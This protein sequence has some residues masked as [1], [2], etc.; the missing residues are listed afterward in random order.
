MDVINNRRSI[1]KFSKKSLDRDVIIKLL[2]AA[3]QAP[4]AGN[5]RPWEFIVVEDKK[6]LTS[7]ADMSP[8]SACIAGAA[9]AIVFLANKERMRFPE[10]WQQDM[11]A[12]AE[13]LLLEAASLDLGAIWLGVS[14]DNKRE[15]Y[16]SGL[17]KLGDNLTPFCVIPVG[18]PAEGQENKFI[19]RYEE[20]RVHFSD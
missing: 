16:L 4:S 5:Q 20:N 12:A 18:Y 10:N 7:M 13:N 17:F 9:A 2:K 11:S 1:R 14:P 15:T 6:T 19:D 3:M 8:Y